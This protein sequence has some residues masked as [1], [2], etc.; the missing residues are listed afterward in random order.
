MRISTK[1]RYGTRVMVELARNH[2]RGPA[3]ARDLARRQ[4]L[5]PKYVEQLC[6]SLK[7]AGLV[8]PVR[9]ARG[10]YTLSRAPDRI[11]LREVFEALEGPL[12]LVHCTSDHAR[13]PRARTCVTQEIWAEIE[14][15]VNGVLETRTLQDLAEKRRNK[16][17]APDYHI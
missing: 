5:S 10:G 13:C 8:T 1:G 9:G 15:R 12:R 7:T 3:K 4:A 17:K 11:S 16:E 14:G 2:G 6:A